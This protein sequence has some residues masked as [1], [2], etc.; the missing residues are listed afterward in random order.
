MHMET[1]IYVSQK[2][3]V[4]MQVYYYHGCKLLSTIEYQ[5]SSKNQSRKVVLEKLYESEKKQS[6][7]QL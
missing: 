5:W 7:H 2:N 6:I 1:T 4:D 3:L